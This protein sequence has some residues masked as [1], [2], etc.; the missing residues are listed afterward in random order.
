[1]FAFL[2]LFAFRVEAYLQPL[3]PEN[4]NLLYDMAA[5]G[6]VSAINNARARGLNIDSV[7]ANGDTGLCVAAKY[8][9][10]RAFKSFL[11]SGANPSHRCTWEIDGYRD[12]LRSVVENPVKNADTAVAANKTYVAGSTGMSLT[13]KALIGAGII[14]AGAGTAVAL[15]GGG[16]DD[17]V[18]P[19]CVHGHWVGE[20]CV[21]NTPAYTGEKC[22]ECAA[23][24]GH[25][26]TNEC[27]QTLACA[28]GGYQKGAKCV[29]PTA[30]ND[31]NL[32]EG[33]GSGYGKN[34]SGAC[35]LLSQDVYGENSNANYNYESE[36]TVNN[37]NY[38]NSY[39]LFYDAGQTIHWHYLEQN[40][41]ANTYIDVIAKEVEIPVEGG[42]EGETE[43]VVYGGLNENHKITVTNNSDGRTYGMYSN[44]A[45]IIYNNYVETKEACLIALGTD[46]DIERSQPG[47]SYAYITVNNTGDG[48]VFGIWGNGAILSG[49]FGLDVAMEGSEAYLYSYITVNNNGKGSA[50]GIYNYADNGDDSSESSEK[51]ISN[52][53]KVVSDTGNNK[54]FSLQSFIDVKNTGT[55]DAYGMHINKGSISNSGIVHVTA[56]TGNA[57]GASSTG[58]SVSNV[59]EYNEVNPSE[60][61]FATS[62]TGDAY[63]IYADGGEVNNGRWVSATSETGNAIGIYFKAEKKT[64]TSNQNEQNDTDNTVI[65]SSKITAT[66]TTGNAYGIYNI[67]GKVINSTQRYPIEV[68]SVS[69]TA[70][71]IYSNGGSVENT[72]RIWVYGPSDTTYGIYATNGAKVKNSGQFEFVINGDEMK[73]TTETTCVG[74][75]TSSCYTPMGEK[76]IYLTGNATLLNAGSVSTTGALSLGSR[77]VSVTSGGSFSA[78]SISGNLNV[79]NEVVS[80]GFENKYVLEDAVLADDVSALTLTSGSPLFDASLDGSDI[81]LAKK[82]FADVLQNNSSVAAFLEQN[83]ALQNDAALFKDLKDKTSLAEVQNAVSSLTGQDVLSRFS[84]EDLL[85]EKELNFDVSEKM[86]ELKGDVFSITG[87]IKPQMFSGSGARAQYVLSGKKAENTSFGVGLSVSDINSDDGTRLNRRVSRYIQLL[88]PFKATNKGFDFLVSPKLG[89]AY[90]TYNRHGYGN[91]NYDGKIEKRTLA[92]SNEVRYPVRLGMF[93]LSP[94]AELNLS[95]FETKIKEDAKKYSLSSERNNTYSAET[96]IGAYL[97]M[98]KDF[99]KTNRFEFMLGALLYHEFANPYELK[100]SMNDMNGYFKI[101]DEKRRNDYVVLRSKFSYDI[102]NL[103]LYGSLLSYMDS[104]YR[105]RADLGFKYAF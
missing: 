5:R 56:S 21:C 63:G 6:E 40:K 34:S 53:Y 45:E 81:V 33:C 74:D 49:D 98:Q 90:G 76:A 41:F 101:T 77:G 14:A 64:N 29:C 52:V 78:N 96:G 104:E 20:T 13:T 86:F 30:Y 88:A 68:E 37:N 54:Y 51:S 65:N 3:S 91:E 60:A 24:Y 43:K 97:S 25:Y 100:L 80:L 50:Y 58:G 28:H 19:N 67:G 84:T 70:V 82:D 2:G 94:A 15:G 62:T 47:R 95:A 71:G 9:N 46:S 83:Y 32:C 1:M 55:G 72:G 44:N 22:N 57:Y 87:D 17:K 7:N 23:G 69:G 103:S 105:T 39:G 12:F 89:Y 66:S 38:A 16:S 27:Y 35:V 73:Y 8:R 11:Q 75:I 61:L 42:E 31:G 99:S 36:I 4:F 10:K 79:A 92:V 93:E 26:G 48:N 18:D 59:K 102:G 85:L